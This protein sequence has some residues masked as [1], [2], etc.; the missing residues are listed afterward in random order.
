VLGSRDLVEITGA[1]FWTHANSTPWLEQLP[2]QGQRF[3]LGRFPEA[4]TPDRLLG[5]EPETI[6]RDGITLET[7]FT[8]G[9][10]P[11]HLCYFLRDAGVLFGG[12]TL[13]NL[14][15]G[16][17]DL[18]GA[19]HEQLMRS[20]MERIL[21]LGDDVRVLPGH[22]AATTVGFERQNNPFILAYLDR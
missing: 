20:I 21:P 10:A 9:H 1:P 19:D 14:S 12:D 17:T 22:M 18:P 5:D 3:G 8:P 6:T 7:I 2:E 13:F 15:I 16:R 4:A 11:D